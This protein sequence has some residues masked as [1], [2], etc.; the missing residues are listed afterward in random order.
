MS[1]TTSSGQ[2]V[3]SPPGQSPQEGAEGPSREHAADPVSPQVEDQP[4]VISNRGPLPTLPPPKAGR[5]AEKS[6]LRIGGRLEHFELLEYVGGG[7]MG[8]VFR[9]LD[10]RLGRIVALKVLSRAQA[11]ELETLMRFRNEARSAARL[12]HEG[13]AQ[14]YYLGE[15]DGLPFISFEFIEGVNVRNLVAEKG[16]L[17][18]AEAL[19]Y[20]VQVAEALAHAASHKVVHRDIKPSNVL[21]TSEGRAKLIDMGL[22]RMRKLGASANELTASGVTLGT[23][24]YISPEQARDPRT[25]DT[26]S[27]IYSLGCTLFYMLTGRPPFPEGTVL[28]KLLQHQEIEPPDVREFR[29][30]LPEE[31]SRVVRKMMAKEPHRRYQDSSK[32]VE[33]LLLLADQ[34][35]LRPLAPGHTAWTA[36]EEPKVSF[37]RRHLP[38]MA[39]TAAMVVVVVLL[40]ALWTPSP[41]QASRLPSTWRSRPEGL[42]PNSAVRRESPSPGIVG[43]DAEPRPPESSGRGANVAAPAESAPPDS[44]A[45]DTPR[46]PDEPKPAA[47]TNGGVEPQKVVQRTPAEIVEPNPMDALVARPAGGSGLLP[48]VFEAG[49]SLPGQPP[50][51][52]S[53]QPHSEDDG[54]GLTGGAA[55]P[56]ELASAG[57]L[58]QPIPKR[59]NVLVVDPN[60]DGEN[61]FA[62]L[63]AACST[64]GSG[65]VIELRY[66]GRL[67][68][69][70]LTLANLE[71]TI[72]AGEGFQPIVGFRTSEVDPI[73]YPRSMLTLIGSRLSLAG[74]A[75]EFDIHK[76]IPTDAWSLFEISPGEQVQLERCWLTIRNASAERSAYHQEV[77]FFRLKAAPGANVVIQEEPDEAAGRA[78]ILLADSVIRGEAVCLWIED[79][80]PVHLDW[81]SGFLATTEQLLVSEGGERAPR[82]SDA[83]Q[84]DLG[85][86]TAVV[87]GGLCRLEHSE[88]APYQLPA[89]IK[90]AESVFLLAP[91]ASLIEQSGVSDMEESPRRITWIGE[92]NVYQGFTCFWKIRHLDPAIRSESKAFEEWTAYWTAA[93]ERSPRTGVIEEDKLP[94]PDRPVHTLTPDDYPQIEVPTEADAVPESDAATPAD[95]AAGGA[96]RHGTIGFQA[97]G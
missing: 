23:F 63:G 34:I 25:A 59:N 61:A 83:V 85:Q 87:D 9:A 88:F 11:G 81:K 49:V 41:Q 72:R 48:E 31:V 65:D 33:A 40:Q 58:A 4:T 6:D 91:G 22:A 18:L 17:K 70:P 97:G 94:G 55:S 16:T 20:T 71:L 60:G 73:G 56:T 43:P 53:A 5:E 28:Q 39:P 7:G 26:R 3:N 27:D 47:V 50:S 67:E 80:Q 95:Q 93:N 37:F 54:G 46:S 44:E 75:I 74:V 45:Q 29:P 66:T 84:I 21:I 36:G 10:T 15:E 14:V 13:I 96:G 38:W 77:A 12:N 62:T 86:L 82:P 92:H 2:S 42:A 30:D 19:S 8:R 32:L 90:A 35:G 57:P 24:D 78:A 1:D 69:E 89:H 64:A 76:D 51:G 52:M 68:E 79:L